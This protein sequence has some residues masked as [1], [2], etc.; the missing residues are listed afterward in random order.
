MSY[1]A[2]VNCRPLTYL[3]A[4][5]LHSVNRRLRS[6]ILAR[7]QFAGILQLRQGLV[8]LPILSQGFSQLQMDL[9]NFGSAAC[10]RAE[11]FDRFGALTQTHKGQSE[12]V[13]GHGMIR[14][15]RDR[16]ASRLDCGLEFLVRMSVFSFPQLFTLSQLHER[17]GAMG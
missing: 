16:S 17:Q 13:M 4:G 7:Q 5:W 6:V 12:E 2:G 15:Q 10:R 11:R 8:P 3:S 9:G 14:F 1:R